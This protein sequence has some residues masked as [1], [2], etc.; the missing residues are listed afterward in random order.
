[1]ATYQN[2]KIYKLTNG[3]TA[4]IY[5]GSTKQKLCDRMAGH[6]RDA[7]A[8]Y[9]SSL[10]EHMNLVGVEHFKIV[11]IEA[12]PCNTKEELHAREEYWRKEL[13]ATLNSQKCYVEGIKYNIEKKNHESQY[14]K[15]YYEENRVQILENCKQY[16]AQNADKI[17]AR[18]KV[19]NEHNKAHYQAVNK[20]YREKN[21]VILAAKTNE[22]FN[23]PCGGKYTKVNRTKHDRSV[24]HQNWLALQ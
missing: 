14:H 2:G 13:N 4:N 23:C 10:H 3:I 1:M 20:Q 9:S 11:Q 6:R 17:V 19:Y 21:K 24:N 8:N 15:K 22:K 12:F 18:K 16:A 7:N 5:V